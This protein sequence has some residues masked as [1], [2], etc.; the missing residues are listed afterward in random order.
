[1]C[2]LVISVISNKQSSHSERPYRSVSLLSLLCLL[3]L[4]LPFEPLLFIR[5]LNLALQPKCLL[6]IHNRRKG[7]WPTTASSAITVPTSTSLAR[8]QNQSSLAS[9]DNNVPIL[10]AASECSTKMCQYYRQ[11]VNVQ[12]RCANTTGSKSM[13]N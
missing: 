3:F 2:K 4:V 5:R 9:G 10:Q 11:Q 1:M 12:L 8:E 6:D 13:F 7:D